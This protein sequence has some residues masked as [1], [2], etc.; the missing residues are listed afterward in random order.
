MAL[1]TDHLVLAFVLADIWNQTLIHIAQLFVREVSAIV[2]SITQ[3][4]SMDACSIFA[5]EV[6][7]AIASTGVRT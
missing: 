1:V 7:G 6:I 2:P 4:I 3:Q 5:A